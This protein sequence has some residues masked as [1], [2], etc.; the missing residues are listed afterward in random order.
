MTDPNTTYYYTSQQYKKKYFQEKEA[1]VKI[2]VPLTIV[3]A[4]GVTTIELNYNLYA[5]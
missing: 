1:T 2:S 5:S 4:L 3:S